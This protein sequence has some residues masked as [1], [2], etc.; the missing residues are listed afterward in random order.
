MSSS[1]DDCLLLA[2]CEA[3]IR[4]KV[5]EILDFDDH[6]I[7]GMILRHVVRCANS[8]AG[9]D[10]DI[11]GLRKMLAI[12]VD[13]EHAATLSTTLLE[14]PVRPEGGGA[15]RALLSTWPFDKV[16]GPLPLDAASR[17]S[18]L[19]DSCPLFG[20]AARGV[21][22]RRCA[23][24]S[25][26]YGVFATRQL[27]RGDLVG[28]YLGERLTFNSWWLRHGAQRDA[29]GCLVGAADD[30]SAAALRDRANAAERHARLEALPE[31]LRPLGGANN[32]GAYVFKLPPACQALLDGEPVHCI[33]AED[34]NRSSWCRFINHAPRED[35]QSCN[36]EVHID[37][38]ANV[39]FV[40]RAERVERGQE[41]RFDYG[42]TYF[43]S[44]TGFANFTPPGTNCTEG[45]V[46]STTSSMGPSPGVDPHSAIA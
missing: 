28:V 17:A 38:L 30:G 26:G 18:A 8:G 12:L 34:P 22:V 13:E 36:V 31:G 32:G 20:K 33:D 27:L 46:P 16:V 5:I 45:V 15:R 23:D 25:I 43:S 21:E 35:L 24:P 3:R 40:V 9:D 29:R 14:E 4:A 39:W 11:P 6:V 37:E 19:S 2:V 1:A 41:L 44:T 7:V 10:A 42:P